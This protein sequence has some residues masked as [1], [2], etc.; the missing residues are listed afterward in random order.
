MAIVKSQEETLIKQWQ[1]VLTAPKP[2]LAKAAYRRI[3]S[4][5]F[6]TSAIAFAAVLN[7]LIDDCDKQESE[8]VQTLQLC[9]INIIIVDA[10]KFTK[11]ARVATTLHDLFM[12]FHSRY[13]HLA[14]LQFCA[15]AVVSSD[16]LYAA[17]EILIRLNDEEEQQDILA[18]IPDAVLSETIKCLGN[19]LTQFA[20]PEQVL[21]QY[22]SLLSCAAMSI[23]SGNG[24]GGITSIARLLDRLCKILEKD[25]YDPV[26]RD[27]ALQAI[28]NVA[29]FQNELAS[30]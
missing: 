1:K 7:K 14:L 13:P 20:T 3:A 21:L 29:Q 26:I 18:K 28:F 5:E 25:Y 12:K 9:C 23:A 8:I 16:E 6:K 19:A 2:S 11:H 22:D 30:E 27:A 4:V 24:P 15:M 17:W 10:E